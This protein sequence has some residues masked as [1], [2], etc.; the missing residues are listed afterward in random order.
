[1]YMPTC[2]LVMH[3]EENAALHL[4]FSDNYHCHC[5]YSSRIQYSKLKPQL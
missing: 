3:R 2:G 4:S 1:M 5:E